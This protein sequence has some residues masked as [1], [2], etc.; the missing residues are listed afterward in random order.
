MRYVI[1]G[2]GAIGATMGGLLADAGREVVLVARGAHLDALRTAGLRL[3][4]PER[5]LHLHLP[6]VSLEELVVAEGDVLVVAVKSQQSAEVL[7]RLA[8]APAPIFSAQNGISNEDRRM[9]YFAYVHGMCVN[10]PATAPRAGHGRGERG[11]R[12]RGAAGRPVSVRRRQTRLGMVAALAGSG[13][14]S[15]VREDVMAWKRAK[16]VS[17]LAN[18]LEVLCAGSTDRDGLRGRA[19]SGAA[20]RR[21]PCFAAAGCRAPTTKNGTA[22]WPTGPWR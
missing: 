14:G 1:V 9:R 17:N 5:E 19:A 10:L 20:T 7:A 2:A 16:L 13:F 18:A 3:S 6:A 11:D 22:A 8:G 21:W 4:T 15:A 12:E